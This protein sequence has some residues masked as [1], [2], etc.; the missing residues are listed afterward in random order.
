MC[1]SRNHPPSCTCGFGGIGHAGRRTFDNYEYS[2]ISTTHQSNY[3]SQKESYDFSFGSYNGF[4]ANYDSFV[5]HFVNPNATCPECGA[6]VFF[7]QLENGGRVFFDELGP[8]WTK[9]PCTDRSKDRTSIIYGFSSNHAPTN[10]ELSFSWY[11][12]GWKPFQC[13]NSYKVVTLLTKLEGIFENNRIELFIKNFDIS[14]KLVKQ[15]PI[16]LKKLNENQF[17]LST[18]IFMDTKNGINVF[19]RKYNAYNDIAIAYKDAL[20]TVTL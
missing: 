14:R 8:P 12:A 4:E 19:Q 10:I 20:Y 7:C 18:F 2:Q 17:E 15:M 1:N 6:S 3:F 13:S 16:H 9:H 5:R 11:K